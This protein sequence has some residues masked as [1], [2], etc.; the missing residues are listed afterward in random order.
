MLRSWCPVFCVRISLGRMGEKIPNISPIQHIG[1]SG[2]GFGGEAT[3]NLRIPDIR[4]SEGRW[5][6]RRRIEPWPWSMSKDRPLQAFPRPK[7]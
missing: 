5:G 4:R 3:E 1:S 2:A 7:M 6:I